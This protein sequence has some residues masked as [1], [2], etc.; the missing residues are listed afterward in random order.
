MNDEAR[1]FEIVR[2][3]ALPRAEVW[4]L[5]A[6]TDRLNQVLELPTVNFTPP[7]PEDTLLVREAKAKFR[8]IIPIS[9]RE[10]PFHW[11]RYEEYAV[12]RVYHSGPF[13][14]F[15]GGIQLDD[16][17]PNATRLKV[18]ADLTPA[19][20]LGEAFIPSLAKAS[21]DKTVKYCTDAIAAREQ[22]KERLLPDNRF[23][24][25][26]NE[27]MLLPLQKRLEAAPVNAKLI[28]RLMDLLREGDDNEVSGLRPK[29]LARQWGVPL[30]DVLRLFLH[31]T[32]IGIL[33]LGWHQMCPHCR[34]SKAEY[35]TLSELTSTFDCDLC[36][37][38]YETN[39]DRYVELRFGIHQKIRAASAAIYCIGG[40]FA[41]PHIMAQTSIESGEAAR[42]NVGLSGHKLRLRVLRL[43]HILPIGDSYAST[44]PA[45]Y[46]SAGWAADYT[47]PTPDGSLQILNRSNKPVVLALE[48]EEWD[49]LAVTA[50][51][52]TA[53][54]EFR[55]LFSSEVLAP[56]Q[57]V[58]IES[59]TLLFSDLCDSTQLYETIG[60]APAYGRVRRH[61]AWL[62]DIIG[63]CNGAI[64][65]T[66]GDSVMAV[67]QG[68]E[69]AFQAAVHIQ[70]NVGTFNATAAPEEQISVKVGLH[71]GPAIAINANDRLDY[72]GRTVNIAARLQNFSHGGDIVFSD[73]VRQRAGVN[74]VLEQ[75]SLQ[76]ETQRASLKGIQG[77]FDICRVRL[78]ENL[79]ENANPLSSVTGDNLQKLPERQS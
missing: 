43:N 40:P 70:K 44:G 49:D 66:I 3:V 6:N 18:F 27:E 37:V 68:P 10:Y 47:V 62:F 36:G 59:L 2:V 71:H 58:S 41:T 8:K 7:R 29:P 75:N 31:A 65:K 63:Q 16:A 12:Q 76:V 67:F 13:R 78:T 72:F 24:S 74:S 69:D 35:S 45:T 34:V 9:W 21:L 57:T 38:S 46:T 28:P 51:Q 25:K 53:M 79:A 22:G 32:K 26:V 73:E 50:A 55:E 5:L 56:G 23:S 20:K 30:N 64:V 61:F 48:K 60:D 15:Y 4:E 17:G 39:F 52:I 11:V 33:N 1:H 42:L 14:R 77:E 54:R 19:N